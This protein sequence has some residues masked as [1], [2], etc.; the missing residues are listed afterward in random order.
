MQLTIRY[1][2]VPKRKS[3][4]SSLVMDAFGVHFDQGD[5]LVCEN[6]TLDLQPK[7]IVFFTGPSGS[8]KSSLLRAVCEA[9]KQTNQHNIVD[10]ASLSLPDQPLVDALPMEIK[11]SLDMLAACGLGEAQLLLRTPGELSEGQR[12][13]F[14]LALALAQLARRSSRAW[15]VADEF[16][17]T[18][19]R[20][21]ARVLAFNLSKLARRLGIG[22][23]LAA[24]HDD[25]SQ[26]L[27]PDLCVYPDLDGQIK[28]VEKTSALSGSSRPKRR[29][30]F[31]PNVGT[32]RAPVPTG[33]TLPVGTIAATPLAS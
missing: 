3:F 26:D 22:C 5:H 31:F 23:L 14:R 28:V 17:A 21:L 16:T 4:G 8:G 9:L 12:Y 18:L 25:V 24:T 32:V 11:E 2:F 27:D 19:D 7:Q 1:P 33:P 10:I 15:L 20:T 13:R 30:S 6:L 29:I